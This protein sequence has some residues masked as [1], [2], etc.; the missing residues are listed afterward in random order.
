MS[1]LEVPSK[2]I[3]A[4]INLKTNG[5]LQIPVSMGLLSALHDHLGNASCSLENCLNYQH[6]AKVSVHALSSNNETY[7]IFQRLDEA[8]QIILRSSEIET[9]LGTSLA[10]YSEIHF[11]PPRMNDRGQ[12]AGTISFLRPAVMERDADGSCET[13]EPGEFAT[14]VYFYDPQEGLH[15]QPLYVDNSMTHSEILRFDA[16]QLLVSYNAYTICQV[17]CID[18]SSKSSTYY[19]LSCSTL[20]EKIHL[21]LNNSFA[22]YYAPNSEYRSGSLTLL[23]ITGITVQGDRI[24]GDFQ[25]E[26][27]LRLQVPGERLYYSVPFIVKGTFQGDQDGIEYKI[28]SIYDYSSSETLSGTFPPF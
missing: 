19:P 2:N 10:K 9:H 1:I 22:E 28:Q 11:S 21:W 17:L 7:I 23:R 15:I 13:L 16:D 8:P 12:V 6:E 26:V 27:S 25:G 20:T 18:L 3:F 24:S 5:S 14:T 4:T